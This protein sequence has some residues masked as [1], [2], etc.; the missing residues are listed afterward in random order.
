MEQHLF[1]EVCFDAEIVPRLGLKQRTIQIDSQRVVHFY[2]FDWRP[3]ESNLL[4]SMVYQLK[5]DRCVQALHYYTQMLVNQIWYD[6]HQMDLFN[7][8]LPL[9]G[10]KKT[11]V[12]SQ[13]IAKQVAEA[14]EYPQV[15]L[16][17]KRRSDVQQ[18]KLNSELR[19]KVEIEVC[20]AKTRELFTVL[21]NHKPN[22]IYVDDVLTT[23]N[24]LKAS[25]KA[26]GPTENACV[27]TLFYRPTLL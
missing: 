1:C 20:A 2:L 25:M 27:L 10:S 9:P 18:K 16:F 4:S 15:D 22:P 6:Q 12:H 8:V 23:G 7:C 24:T 14:F 19:K 21:K 5:S 17:V 13:I 26:L 11:S 3:G